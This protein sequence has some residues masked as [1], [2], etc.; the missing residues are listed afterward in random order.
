MYKLAEGYKH[1]DVTKDGLIIQGNFQTVRQAFET[2]NKLNRNISQ[3]SQIE[4]NLSNQLIKLP[5]GIVTKKSLSLSR[6][7]NCY[8]LPP[9]SSGAMIWDNTINTKAKKKNIPQ[10]TSKSWCVYDYTKFA[11]IHG[12]REYQRREIAS[13]TK[14]M[15]CW[16]VI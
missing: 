8:G 15:T 2:T 9:K 3:N 1:E 10:L 13:L 11:L 12:K 14:I 7:S 6:K 4:R 16:V 5:H